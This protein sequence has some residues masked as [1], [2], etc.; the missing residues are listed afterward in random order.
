MAY[1]EIEFLQH[2][3]YN[4]KPYKTGD[5]IKVTEGI[6]RAL[7]DVGAAK[8]VGS[9]EKTAYNPVEETKP[10]EV[11]ETKAAEEA[12][13]ESEPEAEAADEEAAEKAEAEEEEKADEPKKG[14]KR[15]RKKAGDE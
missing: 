3:I 2:R 9:D 7:T 12:A 5:R 8:I 1:V 4:G 13:A 15:G 14:G 6:A 11:E 10:L